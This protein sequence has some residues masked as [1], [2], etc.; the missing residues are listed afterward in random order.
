MA[1]WRRKNV[2]D[3]SAKRGT[4]AGYSRCQ[5]TA[6]SCSAVDALSGLHSR[7]TRRAPIDGW[8]T[9]T[10]TVEGR[11]RG[12]TGRTWR[13]LGEIVLAPVAHHYCRGKEYAEDSRYH[14]WRGNETE[15]VATDADAC[16]TA[17]KDEGNGLLGG[18]VLHA[19]VWMGSSDEGV[20]GRS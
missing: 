6:R 3:T 9:G 4:T 12:K 17:L 16:G 2:Y 11:A 7:I 1:K 20:H 8:C 10:K 19:R 13:A 14:A 5:G 18:R 15:L